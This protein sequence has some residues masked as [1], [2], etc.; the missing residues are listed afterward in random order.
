MNYYSIQS[1]AF[2][3]LLETIQSQS[4]IFIFLRKTRHSVQRFLIVVFSCLFFSSHEGLDIQSSV[5]V[6][7]KGL[8]IQSN[9]FPSIS[10]QRSAI[11][12][13]SQDWTRDPC[14]ELKTSRLKITLYT[15]R[16]FRP[17]P[18]VQILCGTSLSRLPQE[19]SKSGL[20]RGVDH[21]QRFTSIEIWWKRF[22]KKGGLKRDVISHM[23]GLPQGV[24][25]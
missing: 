7:Y 2:V 18:R 19:S 20:W 15:S 24:S 4:S 12:E 25:L 3:F 9:V 11:I 13:P 16:P 1:S 21:A 5:F 17:T 6:S 22:Q 14:C 10:V 8:D 23:D